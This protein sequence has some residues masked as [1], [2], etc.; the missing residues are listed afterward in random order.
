MRKSLKSVISAECQPASFLLKEKLV[1]LCNG[2]Q[3]WAWGDKI[4][5]T[6]EE[7]RGGTMNLFSS[8]NHNECYWYKISLIV[9]GLSREFFSSIRERCL[10]KQI[11]ERTTQ[12]KFRVL[13]NLRGR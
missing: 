9:D 12:G 3:W 1:L 7:K 8:Q 13:R 5:G 10:Y 11:V 4:K 2:K 6:H